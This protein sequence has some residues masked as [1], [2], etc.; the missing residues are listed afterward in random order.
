MTT[1]LPNG[2]LAKMAPGDEIVLIGIQGDETI[3]AYDLRKWASTSSYKVLLS[4]NPV[5][6]RKILS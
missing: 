1:P 4:L 5:L 6:P 3:T 2:N